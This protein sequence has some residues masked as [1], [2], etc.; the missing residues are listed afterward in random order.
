MI[1]FSPSPSLQMKKNRDYLGNTLNL[2]RKNV[3]FLP[4]LTIFSVNY[5]KITKRIKV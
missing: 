5:D 3:L 1:V 2:V 4:L